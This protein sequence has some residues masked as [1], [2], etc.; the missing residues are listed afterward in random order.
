MCVR[1]SICLSICIYVCVYVCM[2]V[3]IC[4]YVCLSVYLC[5]H[6]YLFACVCVCVCVCLLHDNMLC[7][8]SEFGTSDTQW[9]TG[10]LLVLRLN[11]Q[12]YGH[13]EGMLYFCTEGMPIYL[14]QHPDN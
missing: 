8:C 12:L 7:T 11:V 1:V 9:R 2:Y 5:V 6:M 4:M 3:C 14:N 10:V 13:L